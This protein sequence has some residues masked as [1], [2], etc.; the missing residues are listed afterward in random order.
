[1]ENNNDRSVTQQQVD[2]KL[3]LQ[4]IDSD[5]LHQYCEMLLNTL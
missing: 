4:G 3:V 1:M 2:E 5:T